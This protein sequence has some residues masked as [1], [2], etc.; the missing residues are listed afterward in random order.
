MNGRTLVGASMLGILWG[1]S[2]SAQQLPRYNIEAT[3]RTAQALTPQDLDPVQGCIRDETQAE[4]QLQTVWT[5]ALA[6]HRDACAA[7]TQ[8]EGSPSYV[9]VLTC[10][11]MYQGGPSTAPPRRRRQP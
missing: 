5:S 2:A 11:E 8:V 3:C 10:L 7:E 6:A 1:L 9:D 4:H